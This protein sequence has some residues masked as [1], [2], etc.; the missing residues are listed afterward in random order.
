MNLKKLKDIEEEFLTFYPT[1]FEDAK[2][3]P[4]M[5]KFNP[6]K[7]EEF[8]KENLKKENFSNPNLVVDAFFKIIQKSV[9][10]SLFDKLKFRD[11]LESLTSYEK[12]MLSIELYEL[13]HGNIKNGFD[14]LVDFLKQYNLAKWTIISVILYYNDRQKEYFVK[15]T[16]TKNVIKYFEIKDLVYK[17]TPSF[18][19]YNAYKKMLNEM[20]KNVHK[21]LS[22]DNAAFTGFLRIGMED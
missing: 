9:L 21:S 17:P 19:F 22:P 2:F 6:S 14:G 11:M 3:F 15:P 4:T 20:K 12:D 5:K 10:I 13:L 18:E 16:T 8:T 1:G 7:L